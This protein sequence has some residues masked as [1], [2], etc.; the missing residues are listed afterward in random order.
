MADL[1]ASG[2][3]PLPEG[4]AP[5]KAGQTGQEPDWVW[6]ARIRRPQGRKGEVFADLLTDFPEKFADRRQLWLV[7]E[8]VSAGR[9][10]AAARP[11]A[12]PREVELLHHWLHKG[13][14]VLHFS[15]VASIS[16]AETLAGLI[17]AIPRAQRAPLAEDETYIGDLIGCALVDVSRDPPQFVGEIEDVDRTAGPVALLVL[18]APG[19]AD[20]I[21]VPFAKSYLRKIDLVARRVEMALPEGLTNL[22]AP[23]KP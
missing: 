22:N 6:L 13:G 18:H 20:E 4:T 8:G 9:S 16:D 5:Q 14:V 15:G 7:P 1:E 19:S 2:E 12:S 21:L 23:E 10:G 17:V 3:T 11:A